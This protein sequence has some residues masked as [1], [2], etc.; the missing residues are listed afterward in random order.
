MPVHIPMALWHL[1][2][3]VP[4]PQWQLWVP[5]PVASGHL[6][7]FVPVAPGCLWV[8]PMVSGH[9]WVLPTPPRVSPRPSTGTHAV[10]ELRV[11]LPDVTP[12]GHCQRHRAQ[13]WLM[14]WKGEAAQGVQNPGT[15]P[16]P[17]TMAPGTLVHQS[18]DPAPQNPGTPAPRTPVSWHPGP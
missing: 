11:Y 8:P 16:S 10:P 14:I 15:P 12:G 7:V 1:G 13:F 6:R 4:V 3:L 18:P 5:I 2:V 9:P 17:S